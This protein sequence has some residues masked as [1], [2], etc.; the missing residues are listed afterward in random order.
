[1][2]ARASL[3]GFTGAYLPDLVVR[4]HYGQP[5]GEQSARQ[6]RDNAFARGAYYAHF[7]RAGHWRYLRGWLGHTTRALR[8]DHT[9]C[10]LRGAWDYWRTQ[11]R[12]RS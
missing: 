2:A 8:P 5:P 1:M 10:E 9:L 7:I 6:Q 11:A 4:H 3:G 12:A